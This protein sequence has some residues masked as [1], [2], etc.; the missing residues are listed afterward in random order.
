M[1]PGQSPKK[2]RKKQR[3]GGKTGTPNS[4]ERQG[5]Q[6]N[7]HKGIK[8]MMGSKG[9]VIYVGKRRLRTM[10]EVLE[11][12]GV[13]CASTARKAGNRGVKNPSKKGPAKRDLEQEFQGFYEWVVGKVEEAKKNSFLTLAR[14]REMLEDEEGIKVGR[15][16]LRY[17]LKRLGFKYCKRVG[18]WIS[19]RNEERV[20]RRL[21]EFLKWAVKWSEPD[22]TKPGKYCW[23]IPICFQDE[24][25]M[26]SAQFREHSI[27]APKKKGGKKVDRAFDNKTDGKGTRVNCIGC[28][29][30]G[31]G[32]TG[33][34]PKTKDGG[35]ECLQTWKS[36][37]TG[38]NHRFSGKYVCAEQIHQFYRECVFVHLGENGFV[39][40]DNASTH[41]EYTEELKEME[42]DELLAFILQKIDAAVPGSYRAGYVHD[43]FE[44]LCGTGGMANPGAP[45]LRKFIRSHLLMDTKLNEEA[46][47]YEATLRYLPQYYPECNAIERFWALL[48]RYYYD[49]PRNLP[50]KTRIAQALAK[51]PEGYIEACVQSSLTWMHNK[52]AKLCK[53]AK[54][55]G[56]QMEVH[57]DE[58]VE[59]MQAGSDSESDSDSE[60]YNHN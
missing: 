55:G 37:W 22:P 50:H 31:T 3:A 9:T 57:D 20:Q 45:A 34:Q 44:K 33:G 48:K 49:T 58:L 7:V 42:E 2:P 36:T 38:K 1:K 23:T 14:L 59:E 15:P 19:R 53:Q 27:C 60:E 32:H 24:T 29:F 17:T 21:F 28:I 39:V 13:G 43:E 18:K 11:Y 8:K 16:V 56:T 35:M 25:F 4:L 47:L 30:A 26:Y 41:K 51:I 40:L 6:G 5:L 12:L 52:Y 10:A 46:K 54:F